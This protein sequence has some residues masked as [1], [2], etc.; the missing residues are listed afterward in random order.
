[1]NLGMQQADKP[2]EGQMSSQVEFPL[3]MMSPSRT[4]GIP[5]DCKGS[6][7]AHCPLAERQ[8]GQLGSS[9]DSSHAV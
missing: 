5:T 9:L 4:L 6:D 8:G 7:G 2:Q 1:M 3:E